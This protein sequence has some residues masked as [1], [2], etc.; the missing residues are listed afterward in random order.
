MATCKDIPRDDILHA[1]GG[2]P[3]TEQQARTIV[4]QGSEVA[5]FAILELSKRLA[6]QQA[7]TAAESHQTPSTPSGLAG[8]WEDELAVVLLHT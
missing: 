4:A 3:L 1:L 6:E 2:G 7:K 5:V 8:Q